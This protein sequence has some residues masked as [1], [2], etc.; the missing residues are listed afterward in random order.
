VCS[1][2]LLPEGV[3]AVELPLSKGSNSTP[4]LFKAAEDAALG[5]SLVNVRPKL[6][7]SGEEVAGGFSQEAMMTR[8]PGN[9]SMWD[10]TTDRLAVAVVE[11]LSYSIEVK[12]PTAP[13][14]RNGRIDLPVTVHRDEGFDKDVTLEFRYRPPGVGARYNLKVNKNQTE[15][16]YE[17]NAN[18]KAALGP[19]QVFVFALADD[20]GPTMTSSELFEIRIEDQPVSV[21]PQQVAAEQG[22]ELLLPINAE[23]AEGASDG[24]LVR[25]KGL[26]HKVTADELT[27]T[28]GTTEAA[29]TLKIDAESPTG[30]HK[31]LFCEVEQTFGDET[32]QYRGG[33]THLR[34]DKPRKPKPEKKAE[35]KKPEPKP[36]QETKKEPPKKPL[37]RLEQLR[38]QAEEARKQK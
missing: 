10:V 25:L 8:G 34:I 9:S 17:L 30:V 19:H 27:L 28:P 3:T 2:D 31:G 4:I 14:I 24:V 5:G 33:G 35:E 1:S 12:Q 20:G 29:F 15:A 26:P 11:K 32:V 6:A 22:S 13:L 18:G 23:W 7:E 16:N 21:K 37:S 38:L 36:E